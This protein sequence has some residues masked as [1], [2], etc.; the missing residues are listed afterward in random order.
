MEKGKDRRLNWQ[1]AC[2]LMNCG[3]TKFYDLI[4]SGDLPAYRAGK[5]GVWVKEKDVARLIKR[6]GSG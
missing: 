1:Q 5:K 4:N 2:E 3:R 6:I